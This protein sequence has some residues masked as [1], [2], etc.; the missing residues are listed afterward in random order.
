MIP[1]GVVMAGSRVAGLPWTWQSGQ[2]ATNGCGALGSNYASCG[3]SVWM[4]FVEIVV[5]GDTS[6]FILWLKVHIA[7]QLKA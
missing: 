4:L 2:L 3:G 7:A 6:L 5:G 1:E